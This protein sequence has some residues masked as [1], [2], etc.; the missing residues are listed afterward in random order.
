MSSYTLQRPKDTGQLTNTICKEKQGETKCEH[1]LTEGR[2]QMPYKPVKKFQLK[3]LT[4]CKSSS[5]GYIRKTEPLED[6]KGN[7]I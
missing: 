1:L 6:T 3:Y 2:H 5:V 7:C 4:N